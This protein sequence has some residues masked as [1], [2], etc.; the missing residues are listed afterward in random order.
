[1]QTLQVS[2]SLHIGTFNL[3]C[4]LMWT[5]KATPEWEV[6]LLHFSP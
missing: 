5:E 1:M 6:V 2:V 3:E 4:V